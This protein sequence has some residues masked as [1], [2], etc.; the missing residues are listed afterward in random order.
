M[1]DDE[2]QWRDGFEFVSLGGVERLWCRTCN[3]VNPDDP[4]SHWLAHQ[5]D[6]QSLVP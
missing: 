4:E 1:G 6:Q 2:Q 5:E 3:L